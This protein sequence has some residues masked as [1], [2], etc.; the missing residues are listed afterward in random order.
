MC[1]SMFVCGGAPSRAENIDEVD[2][3]QA[4]PTSKHLDTAHHCLIRA[5]RERPTCSVR[6]TGAPVGEEPRHND[7]FPLLLLVHSLFPCPPPLSFLF[8]SSGSGWNTARVGG[9]MIL[10]SVM[11]ITCQ[12]HP[13][14]WARKTTWR[15]R[16]LLRATRQCRRVCGQCGHVA[17]RTGHAIIKKTKKKPKGSCACVHCRPSLCMCRCRSKHRHSRPGPV[18]AFHHPHRWSGL[19][20]GALLQA[21]VPHHFLPLSEELGIMISG[22]MTCPP[23]FAPDD[24]RPDRMWCYRASVLSRCPCLTHNTK[25]ASPAAASIN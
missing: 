13:L 25:K 8:C 15:P 22:S 12:T 10:A 16:E 19:Q 14:H 3:S 6:L 2:V 7:S 23:A 11:L 9:G 5:R 18:P 21:A 20:P 4:C 17:A 24:A 1:Y